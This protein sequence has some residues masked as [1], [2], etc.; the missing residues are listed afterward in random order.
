MNVNQADV[1]REI[2][3]ITEVCRIV[4]G[5]AAMAHAADSS[6]VRELIAMA[7][8]A[9]AHDLAADAA[10]YQMKLIDLKRSERPH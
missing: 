6:F 2:D 8:V 10:V 7:L 9:E 4:R 1:Q 3:E 5:A